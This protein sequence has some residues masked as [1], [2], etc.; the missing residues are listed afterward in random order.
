MNSASDQLHCAG[1]VSFPA[2]SEISNTNDAVCLCGML[3]YMSIATLTGAK[4]LRFCGEART[5]E[6]LEGNEQ[7]GG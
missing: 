5:R 6:T 4:T 2:L 7:V 3:R 1:R